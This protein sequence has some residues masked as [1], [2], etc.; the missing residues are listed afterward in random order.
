MDGGN[1]TLDKKPARECDEVIA[2]IV[3]FLASIGIDIAEGSVGETTFLPGV[4][5]VAGG[6]VFDRER[7]LFPGDRRWSRGVGCIQAILGGS[8]FVRHHC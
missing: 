7:L 4:E 3:A 6:L 2:K 8:L 5:I 1:S